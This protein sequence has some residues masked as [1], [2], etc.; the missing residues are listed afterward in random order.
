[1]ESLLTSICSVTHLLAIIHDG[2]NLTTFTSSFI[3][4]EVSKSNLPLPCNETGYI[5]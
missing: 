2:S 4:I 1:M 3:Y 5:F